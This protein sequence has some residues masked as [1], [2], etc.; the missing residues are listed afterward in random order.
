MNLIKILVLGLILLFPSRGRSGDWNWIKNGDF[1]SN[2]DWNGN[3]SLQPGPKGA[4][5]AHLENPQF[6][7]NSTEQEVALPQPAPP[8]LEISGWM[9]CEDIVQGQ[10]DWEKCRIT[11]TF[12]DPHG[13]QVGGWP[14]DI[15]RENGT[16]DWALYSNQYSVPSGAATAKVELQLDNCTGKSWYSGLKMLVYDYD[17][18]PMPVGAAQTHPDRKPPARYKTDNWLL[19]PDFEAPGSTDWEQ[20][21][22]AAEG[23][24]S[25]HSLMVENA[26]PSWTLPAQDVSFQGQK[27]AALLYGGWIKTEAV[28]PGVNPW[29]AARLGLDFR[30]A[31]N[32]Q[33]GGWQAEAAQVIGTTDWTY[34]EKKFVVPP[35]AAAVHVD[36]GLGNC[37]G[38][39]WFDDLSLTLLDS[40]GKKIMTERQ[41]QQTTD[42]SDWYA[43]QAPT[44]ASDAPLDLSFLNDRPAGKHGFVTNQG[45]HFV[46]ADGERVRFWGTDVVG[47]RLFMPH[48]ET[49]RV[50]ER[51]AKLGINL[52]RLHFLDNNWGESCLFDPQAD[53]TQTFN[54]DSLEKLDYFLSALKKNGVYV[55]PD[56]S[57]GRKFR[58]GDKVPG[59]NELEEGA[60]TVIHFSRRVIELNKKYASMLLS[61]VNPWQG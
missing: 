11:V 41:T 33:V 21:H 35:G 54:P 28:T 31:N 44:S 48:E 19:D 47:P 55:Y 49:D 58:A 32:K 13:T 25:L 51:M 8:A 45:G 18:K 40:D 29:E 38:K 61:H 23:H 46:F 20:A 43:F 26:A 57:V 15:A 10:K 5:A 39:A 24:Q 56:W 4:Q 12:F 17:L 16:K 36:A 3:F 9:K 53:N 7:W 37:V 50:A 34:Y 59:A 14:S 52:V 2:T 60:K 30:D 42:T 6:A 27:P 22:I 1:T